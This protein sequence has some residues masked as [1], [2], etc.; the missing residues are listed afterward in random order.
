MYCLT[1]A[2]LQ[3]NTKAFY[4]FWQ[5]QL[6]WK[7]HTVFIICGIRQDLLGL[8]HNSSK[9][10]MIPSIM[11]IMT[12]E[13]LGFIWHFVQTSAGHLRHHYHQSIFKS[14]P[15]NYGNMNSWSSVSFFNPSCIMGASQV[16]LLFYPSAL[17]SDMDEL[18]IY[19][20]KKPCLIDLACRNRWSQSKTTNPV[21]I[22]HWRQA[23]AMHSTSL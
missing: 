14:L 23:S 2:L 16:V 10:R 15:R 8:V 12:S 20:F 11:H 7:V 6:I 21:T 18:K 3:I 9:A 17:L 19:F 1:S 22:C 13:L 5:D 4:F